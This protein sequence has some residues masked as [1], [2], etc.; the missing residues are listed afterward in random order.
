[1]RLLSYNVRNAHIREEVASSA[2]DH[3][4]DA[5]VDLITA[6]NPDVLALQE[7]STEQLD[8]IRDALKDS[9]KVCLDPAFY[10]ADRSHNAIL[11]RNTLKVAGSGAF[12]IHGTGQTQSKIDGSI[13][14]RH[15]TF[16][17]LHEAHA[18]LLVVN[19]H[20]DHADDA[21]VKQAEMKAFIHL[22]GGI[23]GVPPTKAIVMGDF[24]AVPKMQPCFLLER[25]G[26]RD[27]ARLQGSEDG[28]FSCWTKG[29]PSD[30]IDYIWL[31]DDLKSAL[32]SYRVVLGAYPKQ[33]GGLYYASDHAA[34]LAQFDI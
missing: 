1:M 7:D 17:R 28:T 13:C 29:V 33:G 10:E 9:Y 27:A 19:V 4:R 8:Y 20:L 6:E 25:F 31:S 24:N 32:K 34:V 23:A 16:V 26:M 5:V 12:W 30:R 3:R 2:W 15:A 14:F 21:A 18:S 11:V 22:L